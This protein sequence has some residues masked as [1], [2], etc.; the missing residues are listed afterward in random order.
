MF[1]WQLLPWTLMWRCITI[2]WIAIDSFP[3]SL[4]H[5]TNPNLSLSSQDKGGNICQ[6]KGNNSCQDREITH[7]LK[8]GMQQ[9]YFYNGLKTFLWNDICLKQIFHWGSHILLPLPK[10]FCLSMNY[11]ILLLY[12]MNNI[13]YI[14]FLRFCDLTRQFISYMDVPWR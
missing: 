8:T 13:F 9:F 10:D 1:C 5:P 12:M 11:V 14:W 7:L 3:T 2:Y 6:D 4:L